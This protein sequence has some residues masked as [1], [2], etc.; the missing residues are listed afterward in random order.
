[1][2]NSLDK[3]SQYKVVM[4]KH[5]LVY[6]IGLTTVT[7]NCEDLCPS[8]HTLE[9]HK[10]SILYASSSLLILAG[11]SCLDLFRN[12]SPNTVT[13]LCFDFETLER[14]SILLV[15]FVCLLVG[16]VNDSFL[17]LFNSP[18]SS[19]ILILRL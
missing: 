2:S 1:M 16:V 7:L 10:C 9:L 15:V 4:I 13:C 12:P 6:L 3:N 11:S 17:V 18:M 19:S 5:V 14:V 8:G